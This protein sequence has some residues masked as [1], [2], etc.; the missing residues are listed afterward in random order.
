MPIVLDKLMSIVLDKLMS[1]N[2]VISLLNCNISAFISY[3]CYF[4]SIDCEGINV[5]S[6]KVEDEI[7]LKDYLWLRLDFCYLLD[8]LLVFYCWLF[9]LDRL[10]DCDLLDCLLVTDYWLFCLDCGS[11]L[12]DGVFDDLLLLRLE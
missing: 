2:Y 1:I 8:C 3:L 11:L 9:T 12:V 5:L 4:Y 10:L 7:F 6:F